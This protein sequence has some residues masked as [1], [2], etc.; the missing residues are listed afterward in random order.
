MEL[1]CDYRHALEIKGLLREPLR[2]PQRPDRAFC[3]LLQL[4]LHLPNAQLIDSWA[5][6]S[7]KIDKTASLTTET[8]T[9]LEKQCTKNSPLNRDR[10]CDVTR[11]RVISEGEIYFAFKSVT[12][13]KKICVWPGDSYSPQQLEVQIDWIG[14]WYHWLLIEVNNTMEVF[15][16][17]FW[18]VW[19]AFM[20]GDVM[21]VIDLFHSQNFF[22]LFIRSG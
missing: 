18:A 13:N 12:K 16:F 2:W 8:H 1:Y 4:R 21:N 19:M 15:E 22:S 7:T 11:S 9:I 3:L 5:F 17:C 6:S 20:S 14:K 10:V